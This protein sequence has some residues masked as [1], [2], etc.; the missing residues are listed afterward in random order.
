MEGKRIETRSL[1]F[2]ISIIG[3]ILDKVH[4]IK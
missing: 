1:I 3:Y 4:W 2:F